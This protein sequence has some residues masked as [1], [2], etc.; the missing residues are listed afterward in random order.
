MLRAGERGGH[1]G[2]ALSQAA[3]QLEAE[4]ELVARV[5]NALAYPAILTLAGLASVT[6]ITTVVLPRF[7]A[8]L[9]EL[10]NDLPPTTR[11]LLGLS[12]HLT[13]FG[14]WYLLA[15]LAAGSTAIAWIRQPAGRA[16]LHHLLL[17][18]PIVGRLRQALATTRVTRALGAMLATGMPLLA[19]LE[20]AGE[21]AGDLE[22]RARLSTARERV[23]R[24]EPLVR[25]LTHEAALIPTA[26]Q[27]LAV[28][29][30]SGQLGSMALKAGDLAAREAERGIRTLVTVLE[31]GLVIA[32][33]GLVAFVAAALLQAVYGLRPG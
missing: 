26:L 5:R 33:G 10:G 27:L 32:F 11:I 21:A 20:A 16:W 6:V 31:P 15:G 17:E 2:T 9:R 12:G 1:L 4:A 19:A 8:L 23:A 24:G 29:E 13:R 30:G 7:A 25:S 28:G 3:T 14:L 22:V 18:L